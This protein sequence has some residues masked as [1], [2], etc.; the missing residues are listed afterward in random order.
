MTEQQ[1]R[2]AG[3]AVASMILG[4]LGLA[5]IGPFGAI[6]AVIC[7]HIGWSKIRKSSGTLKGEGFAIAGMVTGYISIAMLPLLAAIAIPAFVK[8]RDTAMRN[9]CINNMRM[10][11]NAKEQAALARNYKNGDSIPEQ[12]VSRYLKNGFSGLSCRKG[13]SYTI[14]PLGKDPECSVHGAMSAAMETR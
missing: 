10:I 2:T 6:P 11:D 3:V 12:E 4:I 14:Q 7:G 5:C 1:A 13:G 9:V 8:A